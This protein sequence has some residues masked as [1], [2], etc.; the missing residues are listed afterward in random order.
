MGSD[1]P[2]V[3]FYIEILN[4]GKYESTDLY[5]TGNLNN[6]GKEIQSIEIE[7]LYLNDFEETVPGTTEILNINKYFTNVLDIGEIEF[8]I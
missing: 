2:N 5:I 7:T 4:S 3:N 8:E 6:F 1:Q